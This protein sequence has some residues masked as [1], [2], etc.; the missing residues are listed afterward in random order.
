MEYKKAQIGIEFI[1]IFGV[2]LLFTSIFIL[3]VQIN[4]SDQ[5]YH[6]EN[7]LVREAAF[8]VQDEINLALQ[9]SNG[10]RREFELPAKV[11]NLDY[12]IEI[13][14]GVIYI[15]TTN[16]RHALTLPVADVVGNLTTNTNTL[17]KID[18]VIYLNA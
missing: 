18:G 7:I 4:T 5:I 3:V 14:S 1:I 15:K 2:L 6:R 12:E 9:S 16:N 11:G 13:V 17:E 10:Y 8:I